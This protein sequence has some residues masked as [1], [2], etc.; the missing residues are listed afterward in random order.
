MEHLLSFGYIKDRGRDEA[1]S[2]STKPTSGTM[3]SLSLESLVPH[4]ALVRCGLF[5]PP[6]KKRLQQRPFIRSILMPKLNELMNAARLEAEA[7]KAARKPRVKSRGRYPNGKYK[8]KRRNKHRIAAEK[9]LG[10][11]LF[12]SYVVH[13]VDGDP[14]NYANTNLV[15][16]PD[17]H[18]HTLLHRRTQFLL[19]REALREEFTKFF[20]QSAP[21]RGENPF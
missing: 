11:P 13:H 4:R 20:K 6:L 8:G 15:I 12:K 2:P 1:L 7:I 5:T 21:V 9:A 3:L 17:E 19:N 10:R 16:C 14:R 18:Y